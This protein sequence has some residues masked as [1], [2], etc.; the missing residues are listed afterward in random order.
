MLLTNVL[1]KQPAGGAFENADKHRY[2]KTYPAEAYLEPSRISMMELF[3]ER[4]N[5]FQWLT[6]FAKKAP[7]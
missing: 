5:G 6:I 7:S 4:A 1:Q 2:I 3:L